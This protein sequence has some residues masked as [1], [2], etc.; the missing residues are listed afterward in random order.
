LHRESGPV[1]DCGVALAD[2]L[3]FVQTPRSGM[4]TTLH[5]WPETP[6]SQAGRVRLAAVLEGPGIGSR[7][8]LWYETD[9]VQLPTNAGDTWL[10]AGLFHA[11]RHARCLCV[12]AEG[13]P[14]LL[15]NLHE[16]Q[17]LWSRVRPDRYSMCE[18]RV[19]HERQAPPAREPDAAVLAF[20]G[21]VDSAF[22][23]WRHTRGGLAR[24][25]MLR[26]ALMVHGFDVPL[27]RSQAFAEAT[28]RSRIMLE[29]LGIGLSTLATNFRDLPDLDWED[30][31]GAALAAALHLLSA[32]HGQG[33]IASGW[34]TRSPMLSRDGRGAWMLPW[35]SS[36]LTDSWLS[37]LHFT[38]V[39][40]GGG[41]SRLEKI[42]ALSTW[43]EALAELR[44]CWQGPRS[45]RNCGRCE[46][47]V[48]TILEFRV[49]GLGLPSCF[50]RDG[51]DVDILRLLRLR[52]AQLTYLAHVLAE[53]RRRRLRG[54]WVH[55]LQVTLA[56]NRARLRLADAGLRRL[57]S[58]TL[59]SR[60][61]R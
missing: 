41:V 54:S 48:R 16:M 44:V 40:D 50:D 29:S 2:L 36:P 60:L 47:C 43:P 25:R 8:R 55:A 9:D 42:Q 3:R 45:D 11:M 21:G 53:A 10:L 15:Q 58:S 31:H 27:S 38:I 14:S 5:L 59:V 57:R 18:L 23:A 46:K 4:S 6:T 33:L 1:T 7:F 32:H 30:A 52:P 20:S 22:S 19:D 61:R 39:H 17:A 35:G 34:E 12:H 26:S 28:G 24:P 37:Q 56:L 51:Q 13:S 49:L